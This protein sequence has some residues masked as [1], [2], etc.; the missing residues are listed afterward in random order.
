MKLK[1]EA[2]KIQNPVNTA[3]GWEVKTKIRSK[4][5]TVCDTFCAN[6]LNAKEWAE[7][8][9]DLLNQNQ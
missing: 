8:I 7:K 6:G 9:A 2:V 1:F 3:T 4:W 5:F